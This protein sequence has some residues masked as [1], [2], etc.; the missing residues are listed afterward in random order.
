M[1]HTINLA[2]GH[3]LM[4]V[5]PI[6]SQKLLRKIRAALRNSKL[7]GNSI[8]FDALDA[9]LEGV[10]DEGEEECEND[11]DDDE[12]FGVGD[13]IG[14]A[15]AFFA[16]SCKQADIPVLELMQWVRTQ[17]ASMH[18][19]IAQ[20]LLLQKVHSVS[21]LC[22]HWFIVLHRA[23]MFLSSLQM[24]VTKSLTLKANATQIFGSTKKTGRR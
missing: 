4:A 6:S 23:S 20:M 7:D 2:A 13:S 16:Q 24:T 18:N 21:V 17:W 19:F 11:D 1:E 22:I 8:D 9:S 14:K 3:F 15:R 12:E 10:E 5:S